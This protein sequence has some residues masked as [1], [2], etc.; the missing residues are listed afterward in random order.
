MKAKPE[1]SCFSVRYFILALNIIKKQ[2]YIIGKVI[3]NLGVDSS[4][5][6]NFLIVKLLPPSYLP[7]DLVLI[8][9]D[10]HVS[11]SLLIQVCGSHCQAICTLSCMAVSWGL[12]RHLV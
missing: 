1:N 2:L 9:Q 10:K 6:S 11:C 7:L 12:P 8:I 4:S 5:E 3:V